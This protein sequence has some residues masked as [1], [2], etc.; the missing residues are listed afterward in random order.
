M[1]MSILTT[2]AANKH[3]SG[4]ALAFAAIKIGGRIWAHWAP[5]HSEDIKFTTDCLES[6]AVLYL[7][8]AAGDAV[9][10]ASKDDVKDVADQVQAT[11]DA[12]ITGDTSMIAKASLPPRE[13][14]AIVPP[15]TDKPK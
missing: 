4:A 15:E 10:S 2:I 11:K 12:V 3:T 1:N 8:A 7:G 5:Q 13:N 9:K 6:F 14:P